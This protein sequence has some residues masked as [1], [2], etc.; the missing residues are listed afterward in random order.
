MLDNDIKYVP[1]VGEA[2][3]RLLERE[4]GIRTVGDLLS[5]YPFRYIDRT[6][7][8]RIAEITEASQLSYVQFRARV[9]GVSYAG[10]GRKRRFSVQ[11]QD[12]SGAAELI[13]FQGI[14]WIEKKVEVGREYLVFGR[15]NFFRGELSIAHPELE[16]IE[17][18][19]SRKTESGMQGIYPSTERL[20]SVL[21]AKGFY[22]IVCNAW[23]LARDR[24]ADPLPDA[25]RAQYGLIP[26][27]EALYNIHFPQTQ[28]M[29]RQAQYRLK[30]DELLGVQLNIQQ[31][32]TARLSKSDGFL[33]P[34]VGG[35][36]N[37]FY[38]EKLPFPLTGAQKRVIREIR[39]DTVSGFQMNRLLQGDVGSG[40]TLV[41]LMSMLLAV[42]NGYQ[43]CMMAPTEILA[44]QHFATICK[45]LGGMPVRVAILT[46]ASKARE[47]RE[48]LEGIAAGEV[49][50][51][52]GTHALIEDRVQFAN[53][54]FV[55]IDE[56]HRFGVEQRARLWT[57]NAQPPHILVMTATPIPRTL[58]MTL[59]GDLDV[60]VIDELPPG[61]R[62]I[63]TFHYTD[64]A[65]LKLF[66]F[67]RQ[68]IA[69]GRQVYVVYPL[70]K[71]S[72]AMDYKDLTD[73]YEAISRDFPLPQYVTA[74]CHGKMKPADKEESMRQFKEGEAQILV[75]TSVIEVGVDVPNA[76]VMVIESA[77]RFGLSQLHQLR[78][79]VGRGG[80]QSYC[81][82]MSGEKLSR[83]SRARLD[84]MC[85]TNDGFRLAELDLKLRGAG[86]INGTLQSGMAFDLKIASPTA[87]VQILT[88]SREAAAGLLSK[89]PKL[90]K[91]ENRGL[92]ALRRRYS[93]REEIDFS[94]IS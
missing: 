27:R 39:K 57:K 41:A 88:V 4:L 15:P 86:D 47:R 79:R 55:V 12:P 34:K 89:D 63:K 85:E 10:I 33:F 74:I 75:A 44:R 26:L 50:I 48:A 28:E 14:K 92:E 91:P 62:P 49:D 80:E 73:G 20:G 40:K 7:I 94:R 35:V 36:F 84:A 82:L 90:A 70:I 13:W 53:L 30:F 21:G 71:E 6:R 54:G 69:K 58:A 2:R 25:L 61:R 93:G 46:G 51:L 5:H 1:G 60:S 18:A 76:T 67:M 23:A 68:E 83:E 19:L 38:N 56:Q 77:E 42:D 66:G 22:Q 52:I 11:V 8:Y 32:R 9:T 45:M 16:T 31:R 87:D 37:T 24:I 3:A 64:A 65:R 43:A 59:Y 72:E 78:G 29:L 81:I 17:Q